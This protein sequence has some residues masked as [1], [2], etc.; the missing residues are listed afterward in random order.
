MY[1]KFKRYSI[2]IN[3]ILTSPGLECQLCIIHKRVLSVCGHHILVSFIIFT[4][5]IS[6]KKLKKKPPKT[7]Q[8]L[9]HIKPY[10]SFIMVVGFTT[11]YAI[12]VYHL[13]SCE[14]EPLSW[15]G[16]LDI[17]LCDKGC[18][19]IATC[20]WFSPGFLCQ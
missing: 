11:T 13:Q 6:L 19:W 10:L 2:A 15:R 4:C 5:L 12:S 14:F 8:T 9:E 18:Q 17:T 7:P 16:V 20:R 1:N 3:L